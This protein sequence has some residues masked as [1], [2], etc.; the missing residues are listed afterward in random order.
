MPKPHQMQKEFAAMQSVK[1]VPKTELDAKRDRLIKAAINA[2]AWR[3]LK[4]SLSDSSRF[5]KAKA[6][7]AAASK[8]FDESPA[9]RFATF[10]GKHLQHTE[11]FDCYVFEDKLIVSCGHTHHEDLEI[12]VDILKR[13]AP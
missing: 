8:A 7:L 12:S 3:R 1:V 13:E 11:L 2:G 9:V 10:F 4:K 6:E 5:E